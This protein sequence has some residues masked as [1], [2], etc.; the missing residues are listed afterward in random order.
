MVW[1]RQ[2]TVN[3]EKADAVLFTRK[4]K[5]RPI[6]GLKLFEKVIMVSTSGLGPDEV[7]W[8]FT[9]VLRP[10]LVYRATVWWPRCKLKGAKKA[11][12]KIQKMVLGVLHGA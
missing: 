8:L 3:P 11:L 4:Y 6:T 7:N 1:R 10:R 2:L 9:A 5:V 12:D